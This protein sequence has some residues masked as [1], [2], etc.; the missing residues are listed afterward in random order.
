VERA[1]VMVCIAVSRSRD[2]G[3][4]NTG[5]ER[6]ITRKIEGGHDS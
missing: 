4:N 5:T 1:V 3:K 6:E 2:R